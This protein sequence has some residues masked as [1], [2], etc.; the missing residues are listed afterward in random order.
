MI[1]GSI[2]AMVTAMDGSGAVD[3]HGLSRLVEFHVENGTDAIVTVGTTGESATL[4][5]E[6]HIVVIEKVEAIV[7]FQILH[8][9]PCP[10]RSAPEFPEHRMITHLTYFYLV[11]KI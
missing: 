6:E 5:H 10:E 8:Q 4:S 1:R 9:G 7:A 2:V 3:E 11:I